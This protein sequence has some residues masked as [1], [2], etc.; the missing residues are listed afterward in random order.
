MSKNK[1][2][3]INRKQII[4]TL[5]LCLS[6]S[7][8]LVLGLYLG[9]VIL[10]WL[11]GLPI[12]IRYSVAI[13]PVWCAGAIL[14][15]TVPSWGLGAVEELRRIELLL[16][17]VFA[18]AGTVTLFTSGRIVPSR[19]VFVASYA[20]SAAGI[21]LARL[22]VKKLLIKAGVWGCPV[23]VYGDLETIAGVVAALQHDPLLGYR[24]AAVF[25][26]EPVPAAGSI[27]VL[28]GLHD[29]T[30]KAAVAVAPIAMVENR[31][32]AAT[33]DHTFAGYQRVILLPNIKEDVF[34]SVVPRN[35]GSLV[36]L[37]ISSN[38]YNPFARFLKRGIDLALVLITAPLWLPL[39]AL[40]ALLIL[41]T[42]RQN[43]FF[44]QHRVGK[45]TRP[46]RPIKFRT[47]IKGAEQALEK[48]LAGDEALRLEWKKNC[49]LRNDPRI[50]RIGKF[51]RRTSLDELPQ[52]LNVLAGTMS[53]VGPRP[54]PAYH[55]EQ[56]AE[57]VRAPR[58][59][60]RPGITG[61]WQVSGRSE[62]GNVGMEKW[63]T[64]YVRNWSLWLD[65]VIM[66]RTFGSV[67]RGEGAY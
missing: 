18:L 42:E 15:Q 6:D 33:F 39:I 52:L 23:V 5:V 22:A 27:P 8:V 34:L 9:D 11:Y 47:M 62:S 58:G 59:R 66:A 7:V 29:Y 20:F 3:S 12:S 57:A 30:D 64:Y 51:L 61:L 45:G 56:L 46:F 53:L 41:L 54:L 32:L 17:A 44:L 28:G 40:I 4:D 10:H 63:D 1:S 50:T 55:H 16:L 65:I 25:T 19:V 60:V 31:K 24:P 13:I 49:K 14:S 43:P 67:V 26:D 37:E 48:A 36:G 21:P 38:L 35:F 2:Y